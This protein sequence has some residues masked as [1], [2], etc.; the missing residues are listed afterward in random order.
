MVIKNS[1][2]VLFEDTNQVESRMP[3]KFCN[4]DLMIS[5]ACFRMIHH[6][7]LL[8]V[9]KGDGIKYQYA[10]LRDTMLLDNHFALPARRAHLQ[11]ENIQSCG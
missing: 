4:C 3:R 1:R 5:R 8:Y 9:K 10:E 7:A 6:M 11:I 2:I